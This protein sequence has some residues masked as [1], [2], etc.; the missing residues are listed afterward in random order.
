[1]IKLEAGEK[2]SIILERPRVYDE[3]KQEDKS[4]TEKWL[5]KKMAEGGLSRQEKSKDLEMRG[6]CVWEQG[7]EWGVRR[8][9]IWGTSNCSTKRHEIKWILPA[10]TPPPRKGGIF[11]KKEREGGRKEGRQKGRETEREKEKEGGKE[12][13]KEQGKEGKKRERKISLPSW[14]NNY[15]NEPEIFELNFTVFTCQLFYFS[16]RFLL[17]NISNTQK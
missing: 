3:R 7:G 16:K 10:C 15:L 5:A 1:M 17:R 4:I 14:I 6:H 11:A 9:V 2:E 13:G 8:D 12:R